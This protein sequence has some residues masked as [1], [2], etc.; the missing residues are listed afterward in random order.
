MPNM[1]DQFSALFLRKAGENEIFTASEDR[2]EEKLGSKD[3]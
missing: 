3:S 1:I 2:D